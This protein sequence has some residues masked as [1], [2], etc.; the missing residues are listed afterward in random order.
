MWEQKCFYGGIL[1][2]GCGLLLISSARHTQME[3]QE[4]LEST[5]LRFHVLADSNEPVDQRLKREVRDALLKEIQPLLEAPLN[6][7]ESKEI[8]GKH[9]PELTEVATKTLQQQNCETTVEVELTR[10]WFPVK[11]YGN[12][13]LPAGEYEALRVSIGQAA[14]ENW[15]CM[16]FP[17]LCFIEESYE[18]RT[19][20]LELLQE[21]LTAEE[22]RQI[23]QDGETQ[24]KVKFWIWEKVEHFFQMRQHN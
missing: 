11:Q 22:F 16:L 21:N 7:A 10:N 4:K 6:L 1:M 12:L 23:W 14:G 20:D 18:I 5:V 24:V 3:I 19:E 15:W 2:I 13:I 9:L 17:T 8:L